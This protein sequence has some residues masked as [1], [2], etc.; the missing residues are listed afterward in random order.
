MRSGKL[1]TWLDRYIFRQLSL[2]LLAVSGGLTALI[3]LTQSLRFVELVVNRGLSMTVFIRQTSLLL[4][5]FVA[6]ILP[7]TTFVY[8]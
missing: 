6:V 2:A 8:P 7:I 1:I 5:S 4:P 3:W